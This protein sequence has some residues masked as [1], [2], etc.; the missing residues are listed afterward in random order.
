MSEDKSIDDLIDDLDDEKLFGNYREAR[1]A[2]LKQEVAKERMMK[3]KGH[4]TYTELF[5]EKEFLDTTIK[6]KKVVCHFYHA[7]FSRC[8]IMDHHLE[9]L[10]RVHFETKFLKINVE[11]APFFVEK[12]GIKVLPCVLS[13]IDGQ[14]VDRLV[15][16]EDLG[17]TDD[18]KTSDLEKRLASNGVIK[19]S[20][21]DEK[22][23][24]SIFGFAKTKS[25]SD[26]SDSD[27]D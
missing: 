20:A 17:N 8:K 12:L 23:N 14:T 15:G 10:S 6:T 21:T 11:K 27:D 16:F 2:Q 22:K 7:T 24:T 3:E 5:V 26:D 4:G 13:F 1:I 19:S 18:F 9:I 25:D